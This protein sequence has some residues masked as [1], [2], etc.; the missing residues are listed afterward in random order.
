MDAQ[1]WNDRYGTDELVWKGDPNVFLSPEVAPLRPGRALDLACG[2]GRNAVWLAGQGWHV[3]GVDFAAAGL[4][5]ARRLAAARGVEVDWVCADVTEWEPEAAAYDLVVV[6][7]LQLPGPERRAAL[8][9]AGRA[10]APGGILL[11]VGH[12]LSNLTDGV[13]GPQDPALLYTPADL[14]ADLDAA[15][16]DGLVIERAERVHRPVDVGGEPRTAVDR[17]VRA[18]R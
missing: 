4:A 10:L 11:V 3:T 14:R 1:Y 7:Y 2:E 12:D 6:F 18:H 13:G 9:R 15:G 8:T 5:K 17:L 16:I